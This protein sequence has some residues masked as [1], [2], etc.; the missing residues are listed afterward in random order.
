MKQAKKILLTGYKGYIGSRLFRAFTSNEKYKGTKI[1]LIDLKD[2]NDVLTSPLPDVD[3]VYHLAAQAG[4]MPSQMNPIWDAHANILTTIRLASFYKNKAKIIFT[5]SGAAL[6]PESPYGVSKQAAE[7]YINLYNSDKGNVILRLSSI[8]GDKPKGVVDDFIRQKELTVYGDGSAT[9]DF[10]HV[11]DIIRLLQLA[12]T[13]DGNTYE[14]GTG[15]G[16]T[17]KEVAQATGKPVR[18][19][20]PRP[21]EKHTAVLKN[22]AQPWEPMINVFD[23][24]RSKN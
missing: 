9:R 15:K 10:V 4:A 8:Y 13:F 14:C 3:V 18:Y 6:D 5:S 1:F 23:Y 11:D 19:L 16:V 17:I 2:G 12:M 21:G 20:E 7:A 22:E 24:V